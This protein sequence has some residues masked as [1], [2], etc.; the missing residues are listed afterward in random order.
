LLIH[1]PSFKKI[2]T[3]IYISESE[4]NLTDA[5]ACKDS[6]MRVFNK[7]DLPYRMHYARSN[8]IPNVVLD[9]DLTWR[10]IF[11]N[12]TSKGGDHGWDNLYTEMQ[13]IFMGHGPSF[14]KNTVVRPFENIQIYNLI[15]ALVNVTP[16]ANNG[17]WGALHHLLVNPPANDMK[18]N[19][20][21]QEMP[22]ILHM[23]T[24]MLDESE[25]RIA[26]CGPIKNEAMLNEFSQNFI[27]FKTT[28]EKEM[29][30]LLTHAPLGV[31]LG[32]STDRSQTTNLLV[33]KDYVVGN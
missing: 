33:N 26:T 8:R 2:V 17:T 9:L 29:E 5:L 22:P 13:A 4:N 1:Y 18:T 28:P 10:G 21:I 7:W 3:N 15:C 12:D 27:N 23:P 16:A 6:H 14:K 31:P 24:N 25:E 32:A 30:S 19:R 11:V 20:D